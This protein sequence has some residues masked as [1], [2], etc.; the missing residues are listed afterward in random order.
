M[1]GESL[2][3]TSTRGSFSNG[4]F[5]S[6]GTFESSGDE[7]HQVEQEVQWWK[8]MGSADVEDAVERSQ[9]V[10]ANDTPLFSGQMGPHTS[11]WVT[12]QDLEGRIVTKP[13]S[14]RHGANDMKLQIGTSYSAKATGSIARRVTKAC[15]K[16]VS[17]Q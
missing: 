15:Q 4:I 7:H 10:H 8:C 3:S 11:T 12:V 2:S 1:G 17:W 9:D 6:D 5:E 13:S 16:H 14:L